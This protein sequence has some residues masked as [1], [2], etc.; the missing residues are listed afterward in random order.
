MQHSARAAA[1]AAAP[2]CARSA[3]EQ[4]GGRPISGSLG[5]ARQ[6]IKRVRGSPPNLATPGGAGRRGW[7]AAPS[8]RQQIR[9]R[10]PAASTEASGEGRGRRTRRGGGGGGGGK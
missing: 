2:L 5:A 8:R 7:P 1:A 4:F 10:P 9:A 6:L 3:G